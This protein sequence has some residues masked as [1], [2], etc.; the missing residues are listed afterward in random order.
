VIYAIPAA[1][2]LLVVIFAG[3]RTLWRLMG[4]R[5]SWPKGRWDEDED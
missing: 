4:R 5:W 1:I 2:V 3:G